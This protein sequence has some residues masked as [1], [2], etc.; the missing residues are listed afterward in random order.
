LRLVSDIVGWPPGPGEKKSSGFC[1]R[2]AISVARE[3]GKSDELRSGML[4]AVPGRIRPRQFEEVVYGESL[5]SV[6]AAMAKDSGAPHRARP[7]KG[8][9]WR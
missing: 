9:G 1:T 2:A 7:S 5:G 6:P 3:A 8:G 4:I